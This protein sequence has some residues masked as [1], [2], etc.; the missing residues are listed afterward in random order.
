MRAIGAATDVDVTPTEYVTFE[1]QHLQAKAAAALGKNGFDGVSPSELQTITVLDLTGSGITTLSGL[2]GASKLEQISLDDLPGISFHPLAG[3]QSLSVVTYGGI[4]MTQLSDTDGDGL[5]DLLEIALG[6]HPLVVDTDGDNWS[7]GYEV[8]T[9]GTD[10]LLN[11]HDSDADG[12]PDAWEIAQGLDP[13]N[14]QDAAGDLDGDGANNLDEFLAGTDPQFDTMPPSI[15]PPQSIDVD[16]TGYVTSVDLGSVVAH[17]IHD[18]VVSAYPQDY[19][20]FASGRHSVVWAATDAAGNSATAVQELTIRPFAGFG[21]AIR[22]AEGSFVDMPIYLSGPPPTYPALVSYLVGGDAVF[23]VD[24]DFISGTL[25]IDEGVMADLRGNVLVT[26]SSSG[27]EVDELVTFNLSNCDSCVPSSLGI[28][29]KPSASGGFVLY[30][31][32]PNTNT[33]RAVY[34]K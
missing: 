2:E 13:D 16:A 15:T 31:S 10:P 33:L 24:H 9:L 27:A 1:D 23:G 7:D 26:P 18:G 6:T 28:F 5:N 22:A 32:K 17:D 8:N 34:S 21:P 29:Q 19:G 30:P 25:T 3:L 14:P 20:P 11:N 12:L 4:V